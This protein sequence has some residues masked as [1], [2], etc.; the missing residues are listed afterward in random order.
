MVGGGGAV[1]CTL[2]AGGKMSG[3]NEERSWLRILAEGSSVTA[4]LRRYQ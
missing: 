3:F 1:A 4:I 2:Y